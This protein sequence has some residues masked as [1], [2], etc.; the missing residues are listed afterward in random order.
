MAKGKY[1]FDDPLTPDEYAR[2]KSDIRERGVQVAIEF[3]ENGDVL[4]GY[5][6]L[7]ICEELGITDYPT[8]TRS[9]LS[10]KEK[11]Q[12]ARRSNLMRRQLNRD[13]VRRQVEAELRDSPESSN[14]AIAK[15]LGVDHKTVGAAR[16]RL[17][18]GG[19]IPRSP[20]PT[21]T[22]R[23][24]EG[25]EVPQQLE[26]AFKAATQIRSAVN[27]AR[28][29]KRSVVEQK[30]YLPHL[31]TERITAAFDRLESLLMAN[32]P[33]AMHRPCAGS[34]CD[35]CGGLGYT[36]G[37]EIPHPEANG[38]GRRKDGEVSQAS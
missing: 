10:E 18:Q 16:Q 27:S 34:G 8:V 21:K 1:Q 33:H 22:V 24:A 19:E 11:R 32:A 14:R 17:V 15:Q 26:S 7:Q 29:I 13:Q 37:G 36:L 12:H 6:R 2:L 25:G 5:H 9:G 20:T 31:E 28:A 30:R 38:N 35:D 3:D 23:D 4:D